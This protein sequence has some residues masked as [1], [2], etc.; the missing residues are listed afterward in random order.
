MSTS[1]SSLTDITGDP[2]IRLLVDSFYESIRKDELLG[3]VFNERV[4]DWSKHLPTMYAFWGTMLF[5]KKEYQGNPISKHMDLPVDYGHFERWV[6]LFIETIDQ[7]FSGPKAE[8]AKAVAMS[9]AHTFQIRM[10]INPFEKSDR[11]L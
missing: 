5:G 11:I 3:P 8:Q 7:L 4:G 2:D 10:G 6:G 1:S 9:I